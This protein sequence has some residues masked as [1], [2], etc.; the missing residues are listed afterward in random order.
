MSHIK[1]RWHY[2]VPL[3]GLVIGGSALAQ[4]P[5]GSNL[6]QK[7]VLDFNSCA[8]PHYQQDDMRAGHQGTVT[9]LFRVDGEGKVA[10]SKVGKSSGFPSLD[11]SA[12]SALASCH[13]QPAIG[14]DGQPVSVWTPVQYVWSMK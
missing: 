12:R 14:P 4:E 3:F 13:F 1:T 8:K 9:L 11:E 6:K 7:A 5:A 2:L 10:D